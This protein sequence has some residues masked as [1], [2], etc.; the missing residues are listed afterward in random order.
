M[1]KRTVSPDK[2]FLAAAD[3]LW[4]SLQARHS[5]ANR[6][7]YGKLP[8]ERDEFRAWLL[9]ESIDG[10]GLAWR[11]QYSGNILTYAAKALGSRLTLDHIVPLA[12][13]GAS[14]LSN[15]A[16]ISQKQNLMKGEMSFGYY[17]RLMEFIKNWPE[18]ERES[19]TRRLAGYRPG[20]RDRRK[21]VT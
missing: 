3:K 14:V 17:G 4:K 11:C 7:K 8:I 19:V 9:A 5:G 1:V 21:G 12:N 15:L 10:K 2:L 16:V 20:W 13:G 6:L 18:N